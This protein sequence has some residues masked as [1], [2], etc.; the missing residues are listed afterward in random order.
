M[1]GLFIFTS[2]NDKRFDVIQSHVET[3]GDTKVEL[4]FNG[5]EYEDLGVVTAQDSLN[6]LLP[7]FEKS[8]QE[9]LEYLETR[10]NFFIEFLNKA[11]EDLKNETHPQMRKFYR[12]R[13][14]E[15]E[16]NVKEFSI[17]NIEIIETYNTDCKGT[18]LEK[19]KLYL[20]LLESEPERVMY[21]M[22]RVKYSIFNPTLQVKQEINNVFLLS[23]NSMF[24]LKQNPKQTVE[25]HFES[26]E[27]SF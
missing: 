9:K 26:M 1:I 16:K 21:K 25:E 23:P 24:V 7:L 13:I 19:I 10:P 4:S 18:Y 3:L 17:R 15:E 12:E 8:L 11:K 14:K 6:L 27:I 2:C 5:I 20:T 22:V